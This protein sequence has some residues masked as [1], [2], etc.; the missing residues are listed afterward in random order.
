MADDVL[1]DEIRPA[2]ARGDLIGALAWILLGIVIAIASWRMDRLEQQD[3]NPY[4]VPGLVPGLLGLAMVFFGGLMLV[5]SA[6]A[7]GLRRAGQRL[8][9][10]GHHGRI[11]IVL[12]LCLGFA[13]F[14]VGHG[15]P[16]WLAAAIYVSASIL[17]LQFRELR[18]GGRL[19]SGL[20]KALVI[21]CGAGGVITLVFERIF[22]VRLP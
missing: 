11:A 10:L 13:G 20:V 17:I 5:R 4:T 18:A 16:F 6:R 3:I 21:G 2:T 9:R 15:L 8:V 1:P 22:L 7:G 14:L 19:A 12:V